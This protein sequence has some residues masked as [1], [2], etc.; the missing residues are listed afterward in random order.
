[1]FL[2]S[3]RR[4]RISIR[5]ENLFDEEYATTHRRMFSDGGTPFLSSNIG[6]ERTV[7]VAYGF[8]F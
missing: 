3:R 6:P 5:L 7:H 1:V 2:D 4:H 8:S